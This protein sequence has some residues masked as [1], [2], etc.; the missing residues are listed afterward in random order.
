VQESIKKEEK[1][2]GYSKLKNFIDSRLM[3]LNDIMSEL[4]E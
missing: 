2:I 1:K 3:L 4:S